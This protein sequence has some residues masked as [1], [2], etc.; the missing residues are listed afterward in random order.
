MPR[1][2]QLTDTEK[3]IITDLADRL[4]IYG[5]YQLA[6]RIFRQEFNHPDNNE[7][8]GGIFASFYSILNV[9]RRHRTRQA[10]IA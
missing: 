1:F 6:R 9:I 3:S 8:V 2:Q 7:K 5:D 10:A 4:K